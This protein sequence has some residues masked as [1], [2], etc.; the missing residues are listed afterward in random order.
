[1]K[2]VVGDNLAKMRRSVGVG[3]IR[4]KKAAQDKFK[5]KRD[6]LQENL[7]E[8]LSK[9]MEQFRT[10]LDAFAIKHRSAIK[11]D[12]AFRKHFQEM[13]ATI[14]VDP[15][16]S[17][18][19]FW[20]ELLG[21]GEFYYEIAVQAVEIVLASAKTNGGVMKLRELRINLNKYRDMRAIKQPDV[22]CDDIVRAIKTLDVLGKSCG[23]ITDGSSVQEN[24][25]VFCVPEELSIDNTMIIQFVQQCGTCCVKIEEL[26]REFEWPLD[27]IINALEQLIKEGILWVELPKGAHSSQ[28]PHLAT[29]WFPSLFFDPKFLTNL[30]SP[31][32]KPK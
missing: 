29:Y 22:T 11:K 26:E 27:R 4:D 10:K 31:Q 23:I 5:E 2:V 12:P 30:Q 3:A 21:M 18:K 20:S 8:E 13:C 14:G 1:L 28:H 6:V 9:Q 17:S 7:V 19:G 15:L 24:Y 32:I 25:V 16:A